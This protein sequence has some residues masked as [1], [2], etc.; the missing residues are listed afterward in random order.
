MLHVLSR[1]MFASV[2][3]KSGLFDRFSGMEIVYLSSI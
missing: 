3:R 2:L 1:M